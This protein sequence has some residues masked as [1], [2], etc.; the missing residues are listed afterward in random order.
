MNNSVAE[1][2]LY[3]L[4]A[5]RKKI[6]D[7]EESI[8]FVLRFLERNYEHFKGIEMQYKGETVTF[9]SFSFSFSTPSVE[10]QIKNEEGQQKF[11]FLT[12]EEFLTIYKEANNG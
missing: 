12:V 5:S 9:V 11:Q 4:G 2:F 7:A 10:V 6:Q 3:I 8:A 1:E